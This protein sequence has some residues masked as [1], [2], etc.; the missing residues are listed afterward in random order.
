MFGV[1]PRVLWKKYAPPDDENTIAQ[2]TNCALIDSKVG[3]VLVDTGYGSKLRDKQAKFLHAEEGDPLVDSLSTIGAE[4]SDIRHV[5]LSHLHFDHAGGATK[6]VDGEVVPAFPDATYHVQRG[7]WQVAI[8]EL[9]ELRGA[10]PLE[11]ITPLESG[12]LVFHEA[13]E[14]L[15]GI[16]AVRSP[17][18]TAN[19]MCVLIQG[20]EGEAMFLG[21]L[22]PTSAHLPTLWC[23]SYDVDLLETRRQKP[24]LLQECVDRNR[25]VIFDHDPEVCVAKLERHD[26]RDFAVEEVVLESP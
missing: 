18:H 26:R 7:E 5:I 9:P 22:C 24:K 3:L 20:S 2:S 15:P 6:V 10:Y 17:G 13:G 23:M 19:H 25:F 14:I 12:Q 8:S 16:H 1:V 4:A 21:D 11:N